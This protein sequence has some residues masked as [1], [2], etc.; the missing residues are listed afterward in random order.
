MLE[1]EKVLTMLSIKKGLIGISAASVL[2][3]ITI[4]FLALV[5]YP[6]SDDPNIADPCSETASRYDLDKKERNPFC[7]E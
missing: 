1:Q 6:Y 5:I 7:D 3:I 4:Y 2:A